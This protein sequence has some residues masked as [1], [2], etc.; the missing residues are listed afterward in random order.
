LSAIPSWGCQRGRA[1]IFG[2]E[3]DD[4]DGVVVVDDGE[5]DSGFWEE[6]P[7]SSFQII[8]LLAMVKISDGPPLIVFNGSSTESFSFTFPSAPVLVYISPLLLL[9]LSFSFVDRSA[10]V[11][12]VVDLDCCIPLENSF[13]MPWDTNG[14]R[15]DIDVRGVKHCI[16]TTEMKMKAI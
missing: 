8:I 13:R 16:S 2:E 6:Y 4:D 14:G 1:L 3:D 7:Y 10:H 12:N 9:L 11:E 5:E 15:S